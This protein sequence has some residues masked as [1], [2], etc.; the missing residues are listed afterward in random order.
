MLIIFIRHASTSP[1]LFSQVKIKRHLGL[2]FRD[3]GID[4]LSLNLSVAVQAKDYAKDHVV[5]LNSLTTF[6]WVAQARGGMRSC[7]HVLFEIVSQA[8]CCHIEDRL[9][10]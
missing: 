5:P 4:S 10:M 2:P 3:R 1:D 8:H 7:L 6:H 9:T